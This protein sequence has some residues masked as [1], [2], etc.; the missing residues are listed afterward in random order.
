MY[1]KNKRDSSSIKI[2]SPFEHSYK[3]KDLCFEIAYFSYTKRY[4][5]AK[6]TTQ[7]KRQWDIKKF[8]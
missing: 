7:H 2:C 4:A 6:E 3:S 8:V 5:A 1:I